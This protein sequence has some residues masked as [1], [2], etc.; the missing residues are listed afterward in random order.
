MTARTDR[1]L[2]LIVGSVLAVV[3][4][5]CA[6][7]Q[8]AEWTTGAVERSTHETIP[9]PVSALSVQA[10]GADV[11]LVASDTD[12][13]TVDTHSS[14]TLK[15]PALQVRPQ[16]ARV[17][18]SGGCA[19]ITLGTCD[20]DIIVGVPA[21][22]SVRVE[23][24]SGDITADGLSGNVYVHSASGDVLGRD[25]SGADVQL[26]SNSGDV[27]ADGLRSSSVLARTLSGDVL[28]RLE[29]VPESV[30][31]RSNSGD[32]NV[33]V[34]P[35]KELYRVDAETNSGDRNIGVDTSSEATRTITAR[36]NSGDV[37]VDYEP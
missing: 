28:V 7:L 16:G 9:G 35:G 26:R 17:V 22:T 20:A 23:A 4:T 29:R 8:V 19:E 15:T 30:E 32:V 6:A 2:A 3:F 10:R 36:T 1:K 13:V 11:Q 14:G 21:S 37:N 12:S 25:L 34:P 33:L 5:L 24:G 31:A 27:M 18:V